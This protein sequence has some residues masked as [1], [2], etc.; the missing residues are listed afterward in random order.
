MTKAGP[1]R[2]G[3]DFSGVGYNEAMRQLR[4]RRRVRRPEWA[5][6]PLRQPS[7]PDDRISVSLSVGVPEQIALQQLER[8]AK[9][10][11]PAFKRT[12]ASQR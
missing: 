12:K 4:H 8:F 7:Q 11:M 5:R 3:S 2:G 9:E 1:G 6:P 10:V